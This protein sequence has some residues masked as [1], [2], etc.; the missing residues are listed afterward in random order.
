[1]FIVGASG[2]DVNE[3]HCSTGFDVSTC[4]YDSVFS[5]AGQDT[6]PVGIVFNN[7]GSKM[8][9]VGSSG[10]DVNEYHIPINVYF[11][12]GSLE[13]SFI[14]TKDYDTITLSDTRDLNGGT[15]VSKI[16]H[17]SIEYPITN[18]LNLNVNEND[19]VTL[20][21]EFT[22]DTTQTPLLSDIALSMSNSVEIV[23]VDVCY[24]LNGGSCI[25][26]INQ[27]GSGVA[28]LINLPEGEN[29]IYFTATA[30]NDITQDS[31]TYT[32]TID[33]TNPEITFTPPEDCP[34]IR[35][36]QSTDFENSAT[37]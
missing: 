19:E 15:I 4:S 5:V 10:D 36:C 7:D 16:I 27:A 8:F 28:Q 26:F 1:M 3:Y 11:S 21:Y 25:Q 31:S 14:A 17:N 23:P 24:V 30:P 34:T 9:I 2:D 37:K 20:V 6:A 13:Y 35:I 29:T 22:T 18:T 12:E 33:T 32:F